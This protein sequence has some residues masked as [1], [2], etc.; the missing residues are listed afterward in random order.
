MTFV[1]VPSE[2]SVDNG[3]IQCLSFG[4]SCLWNF[5]LSAWVFKRFGKII[6]A[7]NWFQAGF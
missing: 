7:E 1:P 2:K 3:S 4:I 6:S 5:I